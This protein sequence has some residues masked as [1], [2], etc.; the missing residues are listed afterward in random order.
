MKT[1]TITLITVL[2]LTSTATAKDLSYTF[3]TNW[4]NK[5]IA[6]SGI[7]AHNEDVVQS[8]FTIAHHKSG[9]YFNIWHSGSANHHFLDNENGWA[10][11]TDYTLGWANDNIDIGISYWDLEKQFND[12]ADMI[13]SYIGL[14][15]T[16]EIGE[17]E[18]LS[19]FIKFANYTLTSGHSKDNGNAISAGIKHNI[20]TNETLTIASEA[21]I[22]RN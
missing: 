11:E 13:F 21:Y 16:F 7:N 6:P 10:T 22:L 5:Y 12:K 14:N 9:A 4:L 3:D 17:N 19:P 15:K 8:S 1:I 2:A 20:K 18:S